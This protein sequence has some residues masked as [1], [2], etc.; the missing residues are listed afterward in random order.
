MSAFLAATVLDP[1]LL[2]GEAILTG[3]FQTGGMSFFFFLFNA[4]IH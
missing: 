2:L 3:E 4:G 1:S